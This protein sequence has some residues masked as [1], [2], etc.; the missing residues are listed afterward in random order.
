ME[1]IL[2][3][4]IGITLVAGLVIFFI[5]NSDK[6]RRQGTTSAIEKVIGPWGKIMF[7]GFVIVFFIYLL[8]FGTKYY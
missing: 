5:K 8:F 1:N 6:A 7:W 4:L 2:N 3:L